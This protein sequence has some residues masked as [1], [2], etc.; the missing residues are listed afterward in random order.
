MKKL[1]AV[2]PIILIMTSCALSPAEIQKEFKAKVFC[3]YN[4]VNIK[5]DVESQ[6]HFLKIKIKSP[7]SLNGY[8]Y[9]YRNSKLTVKYKELELECNT[10]YFPKNAFANVLYYVLNSANKDELNFCGEYRGKARHK[11]KCEAGNFTIDSDYNTGYISNLEL[12]DLDFTASL[13]NK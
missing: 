8:I 3:K 7:E 11:G 13:K 5:A 2:I 6:N 9:N 1:M 10:D 4:G 12:K